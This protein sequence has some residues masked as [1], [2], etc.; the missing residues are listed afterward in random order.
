MK[1]TFLGTGTSQGVPVVACDCKVCR[2][3]DQRDKRLRSSVMVEINNK[4][5]V[6]DAGPDF[7]QQ[8][9][10][11]N[12][13]QLD[14]ILITH[15][16]KD[17]LGGLDEIRA[18]NFFQ[19]KPAEVYARS[20]VHRIIRKD[21]DYAF[22]ENKYPGV[23]QINLHAISNRPFELDGIPVIPIELLHNE[24]PVFG[25]RIGDFSYLTD[26]SLIKENE[27]KKIMGSKVV[28]L[29][30]LRKKIHCSHMNLAQAV[31]LIDEIKPERAYLTHISH[32]MGLHEDVEN[33][34]PAHI[35]LAYDRL[36]II[37]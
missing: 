27:R 17:H 29:A 12:V 34:L 24:L 6:I 18:F 16:H 30:A 32:L 4:V 3:D 28:V 33:E 22:A 7:R 31:E 11:E 10:A 19:K 15:E 8:M 9:L 2:S 5:I 13:R 14:G 37:I 20:S 1:V 36:K 25:F 26:L 23:P 21:F 35:R